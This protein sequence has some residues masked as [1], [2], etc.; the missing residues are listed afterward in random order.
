M[1]GAIAAG[2]APSVRAAFGSEGVDTGRLASSA[3]SGH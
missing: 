3:V 1:S 2:R